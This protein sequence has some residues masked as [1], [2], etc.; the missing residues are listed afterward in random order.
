MVDPV[1]HFKRRVRRKVPRSV[2]L[3]S[4]TGTP[5]T[6]ALYAQALDRFKAW[7]PALPF[8]N[9][10]SLSSSQWD[11][12]FENFIVFL[13]GSSRPWSWATNALCAFQ[14]A[15]PFCRRGLTASWHY[16]KMWKKREPPLRT[17]PLNL[18]SF[19]TRS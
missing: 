18:F 2:S 12:Q 15:A 8:D 5:R 1:A 6:C 7:N 4:F 11:E 13:H 16:V 17:P 3:R 19:C 9:P 10:R 14:Q